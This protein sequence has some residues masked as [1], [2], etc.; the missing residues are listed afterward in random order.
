MIRS[1][2][3]NPSRCAPPRPLA[4]AAAAIVCATGLLFPERTAEPAPPILN[5]TGGPV[6]EIAHN[7]QSAPQIFP[8]VKWVVINPQ[9]HDG[10]VLSLECAAFQ[11]ALDPRSK[12]DVQLDL[13]VIRVSGDTDWHVDTAS[14]LSNV[15]GGDGT[16]GVFASSTERGNGQFGIVVTFY[17]HDVS[18]LLLGD[19]ETTLVG[20]ITEL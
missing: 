5:A 16:A 18:M 4:G 10:G 3:R 7:G 17:N 12:V 1:F 20:T 19:Y 8:E 14:D 15:A 6:Q 2:F 9:G 13:R 11:S